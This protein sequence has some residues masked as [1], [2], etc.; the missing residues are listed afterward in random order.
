MDKVKVIGGSISLT[1]GV[2][3][4]IA[5]IIGFQTMVGYGDFLFIYN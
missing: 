3:I 2:L 4:L 1:G 5:L